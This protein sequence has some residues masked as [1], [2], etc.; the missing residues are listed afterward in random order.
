MLKPSYV[1]AFTR[2][3]SP[4]TAADTAGC[5]VV[6]KTPGPGVGATTKTCCAPTRATSVAKRTAK[7]ALRGCMARSCVRAAGPG[8]H[9]TRPGA[10]GRCKEKALGDDLIT[11]AP[12]AALEES[13]ALAVLAIRGS[14]GGL[15]PLLPV[16]VNVR[17][18]G[19]VGRGRPGFLLESRR[20]LEPLLVDVE[21]HRV[22][23]RRERERVERDRE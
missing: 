6:E 11:S 19:V 20:V 4:S 9:W 18:E 1:P 13:K 7:A 15:I 10:R 3:M 8:D 5:I 21:C 12:S 17:G 14:R 22:G 2:T 16:S 23:A